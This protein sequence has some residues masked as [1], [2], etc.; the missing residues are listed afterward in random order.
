MIGPLLFS[1]LFASFIGPNRRWHL[2]G[3]P[4][5]FAAAL[6]TVATIV[7]CHATTEQPA[8]GIATAAKPARGVE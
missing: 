7:A 6:V 8:E 5:L 2:P 3:A 4:Y 1:S